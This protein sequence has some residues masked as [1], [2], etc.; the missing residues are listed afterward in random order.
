MGKG[1]GS[2][3]KTFIK[4]NLRYATYLS[5][6]SSTTGCILV[7]TKRERERER[8]RERVAFLVYAVLSINDFRFPLFLS[9]WGSLLFVKY[10]CFST[11]IL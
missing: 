1:G 6:I 9:N 10:I 4:M 3:G 5:N 8:E 7:P 2:L 11:L